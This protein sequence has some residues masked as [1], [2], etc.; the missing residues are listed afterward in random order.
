[1]IKRGD[2]ASDYGLVH[3]VDR[4]LFPPATGDLMDTLRADPEKRFTTFIKALKATKLDREIKDYQSKIK[5][6]NSFDQ[7]DGKVVIIL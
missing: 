2:L 3:V 6:F 7:L 1:M 4:V 5:I